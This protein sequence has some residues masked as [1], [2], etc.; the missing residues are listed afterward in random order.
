LRSNLLAANE[1]RVA[2]H[3]ATYQEL[4]AGVPAGYPFDNAAGNLMPAIAGSCSVP[5][6]DMR[7]RRSAAATRGTRKKTLEVIPACQWRRK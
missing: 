6:D 3:R 4:N 1:T 2:I 7:L 5:L